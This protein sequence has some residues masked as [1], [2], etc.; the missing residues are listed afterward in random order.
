MRA[1]DG[2]SDGRLLDGPSREPAAAALL[3]RHRLS[4]NVGTGRD[5]L[6]LLALIFVI[7]SAG[8]LGPAYA[9]SRACGLEPRQSA[10]IAALVNTRGLTEL[11]ALKVGLDDGLINQRLYTVLVLMA[12][13]T[14]LMTGP[15]L[16]AIRPARV[17]RPVDTERL[18]KT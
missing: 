8:K 14:T 11:I 4:L 16:T 9:V 10:T 13:I 1:R 15:L 7:A 17:P 18:T 12:L 5:A 2:A 3:R 6:I